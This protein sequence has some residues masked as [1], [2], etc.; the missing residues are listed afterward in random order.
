VRDP[1]TVRPTT[2]ELVGTD[3]FVETNLFPEA[4]G[5]QLEALAAGSALKLKM[6][7]NRGTKVYPDGNKN[8]DVVDQYR[9][10]FVRADNSSTLT[11]AD[12][13]DLI[14]RVE[15]GFAWCHVELLQ[16]FDGSPSFTKAQG[17]D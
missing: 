16:M 5:P 7:S 8:I 3:I 2:R 14:S 15:A 10:R 12:V 17:E 13:R 1:V 4:L 9:C 6:I 11:H